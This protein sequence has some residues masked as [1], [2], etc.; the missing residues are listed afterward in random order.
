MNPDLIYQPINNNSVNIYLGKSLLAE[1]NVFVGKIAINTCEI[2]KNFGVLVPT[3][4]LE[5]STNDQG[6]ISTYINIF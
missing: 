1:I 5:I 3:N 2:S 4:R 6:K